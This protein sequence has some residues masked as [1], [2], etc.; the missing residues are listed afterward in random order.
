M[1]NRTN[2][3]RILLAVVILASLLAVFLIVYHLPGKIDVTV[4]AAPYSGGS[5]F[6]E[7]EGEE[8]E[9]TL[10]LTRWK[11]LFGDDLLKGSII[12]NGVEYVKTD[13][14]RTP[15]AFHLPRTPGEKFSS[16]GEQLR[17][18]QNNIIARIN[19]KS[20]ELDCL[21]PPE[22]EIAFYAFKIGE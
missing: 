18:I 19:G 1:E 12:Y 2:K 20:V 3:R 13:G 8:A 15:N 5:S 7:N 11:R 9:F 21:N 10:R 17:W 16:A 22:G 6:V 14:W 4:H